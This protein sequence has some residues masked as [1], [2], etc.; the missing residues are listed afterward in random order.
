MGACHDLSGLATQSK[1]NNIFTST[2]TTIG[3]YQVIVDTGRRY[4][5]PGSP[6]TFPSVP[7]SVPVKTISGLN[8]PWGIAINSNGYMV[9]TECG[10]Y[11]VTIFNKNIW[12]FGTERIKEGEFPEATISTDG[13]ILVIDEH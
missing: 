3:T 11:C 4:C 13:N 2:L 6:F 12:S 9:V 5:M 10:T 7:T 1:T 8:M